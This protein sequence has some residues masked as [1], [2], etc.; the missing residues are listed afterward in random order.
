MSIDDRPAVVDSGNRIGDWEGDTVIGK[1]RKSALLTMVERK[2]LYTMIVR[3][4]SKRAD[5][6]AEAA[7]RGMQHL[8]DR[9][10]TNTLEKG[11]EFAGLETIAEGLEEDIYFTHPYASWECGINENTNGLMRQYFSK[12]T[13]FNEVSDA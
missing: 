5:L 7:I 11:L 10:K 3:L 9:V 4:M 1:G 12:G 6:L 13:E 2:L 8:K